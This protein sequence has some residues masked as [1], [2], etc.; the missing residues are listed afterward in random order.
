[1]KQ[2]SIK[3]MVDTNDGFKI[4]DLHLRGP[5]DMMGTKQSGILDLKLL[6]LL[7]SKIL[8]YARKEARELIEKDPKLEKEETL[9]S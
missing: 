4:V 7:D 3:T 5:G 2:N 6:I 1:M 8:H 9:I